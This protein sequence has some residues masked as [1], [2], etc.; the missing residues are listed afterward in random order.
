MDGLL[1]FELSVPAP[2]ATLALSHMFL[3]TD[4]AAAAA[5]FALPSSHI[6]LDS[7]R[8]DLLLLRVMGRAL[9]MCMGEEQPVKEWVE[10]Q[11][12]VLA[13]VRPGITSWWD[14][15]RRGCAWNDIPQTNHTCVACGDSLHELGA[16]TY[17]ILEEQI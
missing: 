13:K 2:A 4:N 17:P 3:R 7:A 14:C 8:P 1:G 10:Q 11:L 6:E 9:V 16:S 12:L 15:R 5:H